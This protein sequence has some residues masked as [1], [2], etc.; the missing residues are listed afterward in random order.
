MLPTLKSA[1]LESK[2]KGVEGMSYSL[3]EDKDKFSITESNL[4]FDIQKKSN[5]KDYG[6]FTKPEAER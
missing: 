1:S 2:A 3:T 6:T 4:F 5:P